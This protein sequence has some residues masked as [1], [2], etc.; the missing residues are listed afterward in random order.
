MT[1]LTP[2][3]TVQEEVSISHPL[4][5]LPVRWALRQDRRDFTLAAQCSVCET[6]TKRGQETRKKYVWV[7][8][9]E[10]KCPWGD[11][12]FFFFQI[13]YTLCLLWTFFRLRTAAVV[14]SKANKY[15]HHQPCYECSQYDKCFKTIWSLSLS[16][17]ELSLKVNVNALECNRERLPYVLLDVDPDRGVCFL[18]RAIAAEIGNPIPGTI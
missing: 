9:S 3:L 17:L 6:G 4:P 2:E 7:S 12:F 11:S 1:D 15:S 10:K 8:S 16:S 13:M 5:Q 18:C 14:L